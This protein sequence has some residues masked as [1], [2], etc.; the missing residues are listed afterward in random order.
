MEEKV[1]TS[2]ANIFKS[3][4]ERA[5]IQNF[6]TGTAT[7]GIQKASATEA[8]PRSNPAARPRQAAEKRQEP[9]RFP[10]ES[11]R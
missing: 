4:K 2:V 9:A 10:P 5:V 3:L 11:D 6:L 1:Q 8:T 7:G